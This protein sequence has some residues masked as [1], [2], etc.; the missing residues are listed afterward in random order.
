[1]LLA[2]IVSA[3][4]S[5]RSEWTMRTQTKSTAQPFCQAAV[6]LYTTPNLCLPFTSYPTDLLRMARLTCALP[7]TMLQTSQTHGVMPPAASS[8]RRL[9]GVAVGG[10]FGP[11]PTRTDFTN[12]LE[13]ISSDM[14]SQRCK[15]CSL[16]I[17]TAASALC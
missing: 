15:L 16:K 12:A 3:W 14:F 4:K 13:L 5:K 9:S 6:L 8:C 11:A 7:N 1:M 17:S 10:N 2:F